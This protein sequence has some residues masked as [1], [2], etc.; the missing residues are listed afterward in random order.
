MANGENNV[1]ETAKFTFKQ[2]IDIRNHLDNAR[3]VG[4]SPIKK[5]RGPINE[6]KKYLI[7]KDTNI[8]HI[9][10]FRTSRHGSINHFKRNGKVFFIF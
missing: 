7:Y 2:Q 8:F 3:N 4:T 10:E 6:F 1:E 9:D 5:K